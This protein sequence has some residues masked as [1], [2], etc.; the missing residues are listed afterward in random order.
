MGDR[1]FKRSFISRNE[2][3][4]ASQVLPHSEF[5]LDP[6]ITA[7][8]QNKIEAEQSL[9]LRKIAFKLARSRMLVKK[10]QNHFVDKIASL[11]VTVRAIK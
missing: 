6:R 9:M 2:L 1:E 11:D 8:L 10:M 7:A 3:L 4:P 5:A